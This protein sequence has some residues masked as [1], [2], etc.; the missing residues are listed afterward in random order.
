MPLGVLKR[1]QAQGNKVSS[2]VS[3]VMELTKSMSSRSLKPT[4]RALR[5][6]SFLQDL[7]HLPSVVRNI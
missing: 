6:P 2:E 3:C 4:H 1:M 5:S 7:G